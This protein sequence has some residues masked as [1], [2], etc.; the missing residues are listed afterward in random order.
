LETARSRAGRW[1]DSALIAGFYLDPEMKEGLS[2][3]DGLAVQVNSHIGVDGDRSDQAF[4]A[5]AGHNYRSTVVSLQP[6]FRNSWHAIL[7]AIACGWLT[8]D[9]NGSWRLADS[10]PLDGGVSLLRAQHL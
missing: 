8:F 3:R 5:E 6:T 7:L 1:I 4:A 10:C 2:L 9:M